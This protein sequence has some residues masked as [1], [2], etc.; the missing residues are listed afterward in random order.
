MD[1]GG[2]GVEEGEGIAAGFPGDG[3]GE[4]RRGQ[5]PGGNDR[6]A[7]GGEGIHSLA[8]DLDVGVSGDP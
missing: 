2:D 7:G 1:D 4:A 5:R 8:K 6:R 3:A